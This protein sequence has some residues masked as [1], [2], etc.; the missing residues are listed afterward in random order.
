MGGGLHYH[1]QT[2]GLRRSEANIRAVKYLWFM[3]GG[4]GFVTQACW[5][6]LQMEPA[7]EF[8][9]VCILVVTPSVSFSFRL[10]SHLQLEASRGGNLRQS[11]G[12]SL[13]RSELIAAEVCP[14]ISLVKICSRPPWFL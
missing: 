11:E 7:V 8:C 2:C 10:D 1:T 3:G 13:K 14:V 6:E 12:R 5:L 4:V 9:T